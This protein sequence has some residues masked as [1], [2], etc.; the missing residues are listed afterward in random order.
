[1]CLICRLCDGAWLF[2]I[3]QISLFDACIDLAQNCKYNKIF[4]SQ[5]M[6]IEKKIHKQDLNILFVARGQQRD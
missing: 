2:I 5:Y 1:M 4:Q 3:F 6:P